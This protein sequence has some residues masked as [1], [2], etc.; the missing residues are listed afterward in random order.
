M[1]GI[2]TILADTNILVYIHEGRSVV[3]PYLTYLVMVSVIT[4]I[5]LL[6]EKNIEPKI[7]KGRTSI[8]SDCMILPFDETIK[9]LAITLKQKVGIKVPDAIIAATAIKHNLT[10]LTADKGFKNISGLSLMLLEL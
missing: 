5:E 7:L 6:G 8:L 3:K 10:L 1:S 9:L 4:E 2:K